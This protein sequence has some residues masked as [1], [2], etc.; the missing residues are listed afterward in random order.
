[1]RRVLIGVLLMLLLPVT[2]SAGWLVGYNVYHGTSQRTY[3]SVVHLG[4][5]NSYVT[6]PM[7]IGTYY[8]AV[9]AVDNLGRESAY[10]N[11]IYDSV[12]VVQTWKSEMMWNTPTTYDD[13]SPLDP[14]P[15]SAPRLYIKN[16][17]GT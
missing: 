12:P 5:I 14:G 13:G 6:S 1:M 17:G 16:N 11:E 15:P 9:T 7:P 3:T 4:L 8:W 2:A 10:S